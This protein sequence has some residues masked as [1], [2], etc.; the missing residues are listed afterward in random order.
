MN[1]ES[2]DP[3]RHSVDRLARSH[4][5][6]G[7]DPCPAELRS[8]C[9]TV[10][11]AKPAARGADPVSGRTFQGLLGKMPDPFPAIAAGRAS[12]RHVSCPGPPRRAHI[13]PLGLVSRRVLRCLQITRRSTRF[14]LALH[15]GI[16]SRECCST[17]AQLKRKF[18]AL[19]P[20]APTLAG[21]D[22]TP[23]TPAGCRVRGFSTDGRWLPQAAPTCGGGP[24][25]SPC[26]RGTQPTIPAWSSAS[27]SQ[28]T[29]RGAACGSPA[30]CAEF[31][32]SRAP[33]ICVRLSAHWC[34]S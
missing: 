28:P 18:G 34:L 13:C 3:P 21:A 12:R 2:A 25:H 4:V 26:N 24:F 16:C 27:S 22:P 8:E 15:A 14:P 23:P 17:R 5:S 30:S 11:Y 10:S 19:R 6:F 32:R 29:R 33:A 1:S 31:S 7:S 9:R 20:H